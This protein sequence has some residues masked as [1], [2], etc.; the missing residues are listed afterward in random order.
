[1]AIYKTQ[2][3]VSGKWADKKEIMAKGV[4]KAKILTETTP[5]PGQWKDDD[6]NI[7]MQDVCKIKFEGLGEEGYKF[8]LNKIVINALVSAFGEDSKSW[9]G[10]EL[11]VE[12]EKTRV[13]GKAGVAIYLIPQGYERIDDEE[14]Y[15]HIVKSSLD[16]Q[17]NEQDDIPVV[18][19]VDI[20]DIP[21]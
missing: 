11:S 6:G 13:G 1:M 4:K 5:E 20:K 2:N 19:D 8:A 3:F 10:K 7:K 16:T 14:G 12:A 17:L 21:F 18:E 15:T 9:V